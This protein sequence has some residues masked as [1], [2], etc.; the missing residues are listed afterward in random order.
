M[1]KN[2]VNLRTAVPELLLGSGHELKAHFRRCSIAYCARLF[3]P[4]RCRTITITITIA[5]A[6]G[7]ASKAHPRYH[8]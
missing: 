2:A 7:E 3:L 6:G 4:E 1:H 8:P 5:T